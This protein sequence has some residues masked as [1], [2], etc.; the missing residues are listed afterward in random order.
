MKVLPPGGGGPSRGPCRPLDAKEGS[1]EVY[2]KR[3]M[4]PDTKLTDSPLPNR[5]CDVTVGTWIWRPADDL[6]Q[7]HL[8][9][10]FAVWPWQ[11]TQPL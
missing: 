11:T 3:F 10:V 2:R 1:V 9:S 4:P 7:S 6:F 8:Y 5:Q